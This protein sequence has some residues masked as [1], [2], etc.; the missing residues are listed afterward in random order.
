MLYIE[1]LTATS[2]RMYGDLDSDNKTTLPKDYEARSVVVPRETQ[3]RITIVHKNLG[4]ALVS[5][6]KF[7]EIS[8]DG[9][10]YL[11][12]QQVVKAFNSM[13]ASTTVVTS[14]TTSTTATTTTTTRP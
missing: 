10:E 2:F 1:N 14:T 8:I 11:T 6:K 12:A 4:G 9:D 5:L 3:P 13:I 7:N